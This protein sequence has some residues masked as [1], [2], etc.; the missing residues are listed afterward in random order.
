MVTVL[1][2][3]R[4]SH[5]PTVDGVLLWERGLPAMNDNAVQCQ[6]YFSLSESMHEQGDQDDDRDWHAEKEQQ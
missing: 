4:A 3:S 5:A 6:A 2:P 1:M